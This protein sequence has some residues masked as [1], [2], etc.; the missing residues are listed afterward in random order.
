MITSASLRVA[1]EKI[2]FGTETAK[3]K[4]IVPIRGGFFVPTVT[5]PND[6]VSTWLGYRI[7]N[8]IPKT[9]MVKQAGEVSKNIQVDFRIVGMGPQA[10]E[11]ITS[12]LLW[13]DRL[14]VREAFEKDQEAQLMYDIRRIYTHPV[15][16]EGFS[17]D[18]LWVT[19]MHAMTFIKKD[20]VTSPWFAK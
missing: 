7:L 6:P 5:D 15:Q 9:R 10:E 19:D 4:Y 20:V 13:D 18:L 1:V 17:D 2:F 12:T 3:Y 8:I 14:D 16:Q 11:F